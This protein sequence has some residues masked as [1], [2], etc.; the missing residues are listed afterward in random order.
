MDNTLHNIIYVISA[1]AQLL[2]IVFAMEYFI[3]S[4]WGWIK[5]KENIGIALRCCM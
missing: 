1:I 5:R 2:V 4:I 3:I